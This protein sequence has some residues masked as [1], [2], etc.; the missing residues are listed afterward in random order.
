MDGDHL[1]VP[2]NHD[3]VTI[4]MRDHES[5][6]ALL[7]SLSRA[8]PTQRGDLFWTL[9]NELVRHEVAEEIILYPAVRHC[10]EAGGQPAEVGMG[11]Q[12]DMERLLADLE[13][14]DPSDSE[15]PDALAALTDAVNLHA[16]FEEGEVLPLLVQHMTDIDRF[17]AGDH[18]AQAKKRAST[19][20]HPQGRVGTGTLMAA[21][22]RIRDAMHPGRPRSNRTASP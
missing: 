2:R 17:E 20:P 11:Q 9:S 18:Y 10:G 7:E 4:V 22:D 3:I 16:A 8:D 14:S 5:L 19:H 6:A 21:A 12:L 13:Q 1:T 15:F